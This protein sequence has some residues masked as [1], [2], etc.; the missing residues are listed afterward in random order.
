MKL[1]DKNLPPDIGP[2]GGKHPAKV[3]V[4]GRDCLTKEC[5]HPMLN[6]G[7]YVNSKGYVRYRENPEWV[8]RTRA[9]LGCP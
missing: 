5:Y 2:R 4:Y 7:V 1:A 3:N 8:C 9:L 6:K